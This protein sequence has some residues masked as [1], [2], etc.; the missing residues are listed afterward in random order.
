MHFNL[1][2]FIK[3]LMKYFS[4]RSW[5]DFASECFCF[6]CEA[7]NG[8]GRDVV[9]FSFRKKHDKKKED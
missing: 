7:V 5:Q 2:I 8:S 9:L 4:L 3:F 6:G 1:K